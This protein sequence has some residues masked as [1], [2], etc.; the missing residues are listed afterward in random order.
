MSFP[1]PAGSPSLAAIAPGL[2]SLR[3]ARRGRSA[4]VELLGPGRGNAMGPDFWRE[5]P[6]VFAAVDAD[7]DLGAVLL[8]GSGGT[9]S[10]GLDLPAMMPLFGPLLAGTAT[11]AVARDGL[12]RTITAMQDAVSSL[13]RCRKP[14]VAAVDGWCIGGG[15]DVITAAD[16]RVA[17]TTARFS[18]REVKV[19]IVAD[20]GSL[21]RL[22]LLVGHGAARAL[23]LTGED[24]DAARALSLGLVTDM[25]D[26]VLAR[27][28][29]VVD[30]ILAN[31]ALVVQ[32]VKAVMAR[33]T[34]TQVREG[35][36][37]VAVW[38]SAYLPS[39]DLG[40]AFAAFAERRG[41][42]FTGA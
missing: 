13:E 22:P 17:S 18:V 3:V 32:G 2:V 5:L 16:V 19:A 24:F 7:P 27:G 28:R 37:H 15:I 14:V 31:P 39:H 12:R 30:A 35:L 34:S 9:F 25:A 23:A 40:E 20:L 4:E 42:G 26:D 6:L 1:D 10:Y 29:E 21:Q 33:Q 38:N 36:E 8:F 41:P 11:N